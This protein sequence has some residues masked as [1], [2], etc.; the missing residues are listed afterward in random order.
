MQQRGWSRGAE[1]RAVFETWLQVVPETIGRRARPVSFRG[2]RLILV[3]ESAPLL[4]ELRCFRQSEMLTL[5]NQKLSANGHQ[6]LVEQLEFR[7]S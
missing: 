4:Q 6:V 2:G 3:V 7:R 5:L 1:H